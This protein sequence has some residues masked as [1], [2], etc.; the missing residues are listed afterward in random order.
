MHDLGFVDALG[1][2]GNKTGI[3]GEL[4]GLAGGLV[5]LIVVLVGLF[6]GLLI[7]LLVGRLVAFVGRM[8]GGCGC[9]RLRRHGF[10]HLCG[11][12]CGCGPLRMQVSVTVCTRARLRECL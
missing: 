5:C 7:S 9:G 1:K 6:I 11:I 2:A 8:I 10:G 3:G 12:A 4:F